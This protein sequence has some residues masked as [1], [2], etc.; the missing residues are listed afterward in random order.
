MPTNGMDRKLYLNTKFGGENR[1]EDIYKQI[2]LAGLSTGIE[3]NFKQITIMPNSFYAHMLI[4]Y[5][6][7]QNLQNKITEKLFTAFFLDGKDIGDIKVLMEIAEKNNIDNFT[8]ETL[9]HRKDII[10]NVKLSD[11]R[12]RNKG[13]S[14]VPFFIINDNYAVS[15][16][17]ESEVFEKIFETCLLEN[18]IN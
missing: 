17:Q 15:G 12:S 4:E 8:K 11:E 10:E 14:G 16:A 2:E 1:A 13:V 9:N 6:K 18:K 5:S 7:E 3:F